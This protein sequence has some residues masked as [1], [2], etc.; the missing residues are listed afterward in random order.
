MTILT[1]IAKAQHSS[2]ETTLQA[3]MIR[4]K[5]TREV[6]RE[7]LLDAVEQGL[8][9]REPTNRPDAPQ[10]TLTKTGWSKAGMQPPIWTEVR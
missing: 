1:H 10:Y 3:I 6:T 9:L 7:R 8:V 2:A 4:A 5:M